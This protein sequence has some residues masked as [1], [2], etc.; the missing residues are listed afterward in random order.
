MAECLIALGSN[1]G[2]RA[3]YLRQA[4]DQLDRM[5]CSRLLARSAWHETTPIGGAAGQ[6]PFLNGAA[7]VSSSLEPL[8]LLG[9]LRR[10]ESDLGR[11]RGPRW[12]ARTLDLDLL[13]YGD[14][15]WQSAEL[16][17]PHPRMAFR[18]FVLAPAAEVAPWMIHPPSKWTI[19]RLLEQ[20]DRG[21]DET[22]VAATDPHLG[23]WLV[24]ELSRSDRSQVGAVC[25]IPR[26][27]LWDGEN[28]TRPKLILAVTDATGNDEP[29]RRKILRLPATGPVAWLT[30]GG[31]DALLGDALTTIASVWSA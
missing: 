14:R 23:A 10:I 26:V 27:R 31:K 1:L 3:E 24:Q 9:E 18:R 25:R 30:P 17:V 4:L 15:V 21:G 20:L 16:A 2:D 29:T 12:D 7:L 8:V 28:G 19:T 5:Q 11:H 13:L 22:A 6:G